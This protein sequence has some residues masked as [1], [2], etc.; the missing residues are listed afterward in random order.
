VRG[1]EKLL[2]SSAP[3]RASAAATAQLAYGG[4]SR[5][6]LT[7]RATTSAS[8]RARNRAWSAAARRH[9]RRRLR[10][11]ARPALAL[12]ARRARRLAAARARRGRARLDRVP[13][14]LV[15]DATPTPTSPGP[16]AGEPVLPVR[17]WEDSRARASA[18]RPWLVGEQLFEHLDLEVGQEIEISTAVYDPA[19]QD[20]GPNNRLFVVAGSFRTRDNE[21]DLGRLYFDRRELATSSALARVHPGARAPRRLRPRPRDSSRATCARTSADAA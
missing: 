18:R 17:G 11:P 16:G 21:T 10:A 7:A 9:R 2:A 4:S 1:S 13:L 15:G 3:T 5:S 19:R 8:S 20:W 6:A 12:V 14:S